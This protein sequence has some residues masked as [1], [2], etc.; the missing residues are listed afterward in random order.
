MIR[1][2]AYRKA[3]LAGMA[4]AAAWELAA[5]AFIV[6]G[7]PFADIVHLLG[8]QLLPHA[9][10]AGWWPAGLLLHLAVGALWAVFYAYMFWSVL[11][12]PPV[13]QGLVFAIL[14]ML[15]AI[16]AMRPQ[17]ELMN[18]LF[19]EGMLLPFSGRFG[20]DGGWSGPVSLAVGHLVWG[21]VLGA[22]YTRP[23]G[24]RVGAGR[25]AW[26]RVRTAAHRS[27]PPARPDARG[28]LR[29]MF[30]TGIESSYPTLEGGRW[31]LDLLEAT[32]HYRRWRDD[33]RLV[34]D[35]GLRA[36]RYGP[37]LHRVYGG[38]G[39]FDWGF[40]DEVVAELHRLGIEPVMDLCHFGLPSWL[41]N[42]QNPEVPAAL[43]EY[44]GAF[45]RRY[46]G[47]RLYTPVNEMYVCA[48]LSALEGAWNEQRRDEESFVRAVRHLARASV[49]MMQAI[50][51][52]R[53]GAIFVNSESS[54]FYQA[55]CP[56]E[57]VRGIAQFE[58]ERR[59][60]PL[61]LLY[62][63]PV[64]GSM[65]EHL[66]RCGMTDD[67]YLWFMN[68]EVAG[69]AILGVDY[70][71]WNE[72]VIDHHGM[73]RS[74]GELFG[75]TVIASQYYERYHR[76]LMHTE[77]NH[78]DAREA[79]RWLWRQWHNVQLLRSSGVPVVGFTWYSLTDQVDWDNALRSA[80]GRVN[81][82]GLADLNRDIRLVG[83]AYRHLVQLFGDELARTPTLESVLAQASVQPQVIRGAAHA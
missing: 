6:A 9:G 70:Y 72:K 68:Q 41:E 57:R 62:A 49:L 35:L 29:F 66:R 61:D 39:R 73:P 83:M 37:P 47:V 22:L 38:P 14:P 58:N 32:G 77:T 27:P 31:R 10:A 8:T 2:V 24:H 1:Q 30:G 79:P 34:H 13:V 71:E 50:A 40:T 11:R 17:L 26:P 48:R 4:G 67:E 25:G 80:R 59:F 81:P 16:F 82:V 21:A 42:F 76:P 52:E 44:A 15:L 3:V 63:R 7:V 19:L 69:R 65:R 5:R 74:L 33:L 60:L 12:R 23:V 78:L 43:A 36:L 53:P 54:E 51:R 46:P 20:T 45:A 55:C 75:W 64:S 56:D 18:P 28:E